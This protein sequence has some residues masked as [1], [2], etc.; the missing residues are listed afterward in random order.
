MR[1]RLTELEGQE[2]FFEEAISGGNSELATILDRIS[3]EPC[4]EAR[5]EV[6][7][8]IEVIL[9]ALKKID[10]ANAKLEEIRGNIE[11]RGFRTGSLPV[12]SFDAGGRWNDRFGGRVV[13][14]QR[15]IAETY[16]EV[17][18]TADQPRQLKAS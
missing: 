8:Q 13:G 11:R 2:R 15:Y 18:D 3:L 12:A 5:P 7:E 17:A 9:D 14:Y 16:P 4:T 1:Q 10:Q 6:V